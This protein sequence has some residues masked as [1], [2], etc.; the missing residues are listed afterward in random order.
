MSASVPDWKKRTIS[1]FFMCR[2][3]SSELLISHSLVHPN[4]M[5]SPWMTSTIFSISGG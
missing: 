1:T 3:I 4:P 2:M 5:P